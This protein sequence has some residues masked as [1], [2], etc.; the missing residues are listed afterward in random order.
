MITAVRDFYSK[1]ASQKPIGKHVYHNNG[2]CSPGKHIKAD[3]D[4]VP[5]QHNY[6]L[7]HDCEQANKEG[8]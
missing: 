5:G 8:K 4:D 6:R 3:S 1:R 2:T 7:C